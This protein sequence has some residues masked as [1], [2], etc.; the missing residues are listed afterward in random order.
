MAHITQTNDQIR[1]TWHER[2]G[3]KLGH[4]QA[5]HR[6][7]KYV[8][9]SEQPIQAITKKIRNLCIGQPGVIVVENICSVTTNL[10]Y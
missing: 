3:Y 10:I 1:L 4:T 9:L 8:I 7:E 2:T 6:D 5:R